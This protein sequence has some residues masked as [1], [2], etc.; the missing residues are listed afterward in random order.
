MKDFRLTRKMLSMGG[1]FYPTGYAFIMFPDIEYARQAARELET[2]DDDILLLTPQTILEDLAKAD[3]ESDL[4]LPSVGTEGDTVH[5]FVALAQDGHHA[6]MIPV[7]STE[8]TERVM[9]VVRKLPFSYAQRYH[10]L[11]IEDLE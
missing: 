3:G 2:G 11:I 6:L 5:K 9:R 4:L 7:D 8:A 10:M 1:V